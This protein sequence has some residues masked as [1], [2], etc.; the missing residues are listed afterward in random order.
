MKIAFV[1]PWYGRDIGGGAEAECRGLVHSL[2]Q[3]R[4]DIHIE[5][6]TTCMKEFSADWNDNFFPSGRYSDEGVTVHRFPITPV[7]RSKFHPMNGYRLMPS[8]LHDLFLAD[9]NVRSP[10][11]QDE[12]R[13]YFDAMIQS[14]L[15]MNELSQRIHEFDIFI[16][17][18]YM[19]STAIE[20][21][22]RVGKKGVLIPCLHQE[23]YAF[24]D[25]IRNMFQR[26][27]GVLYHVP[28]E[29]KFGRRLYRTEP[30]REFLIGE[31]VDVNP[32]T[33]K[34]ERFRSARRLTRPYILYAGRKIEGKNLPLLVSFHSA[35]RE[36][37]G[38]TFPDLVIIGGGDLDYSSLTHSH[39]IHDLGFVSLEEKFDA[40]AG[41]L[42]LCQPSLNESFSIVMMEA[43]L[44]SRPILAHQH[45]DVTREHCELSGGGLIF[46]S[47][48]SYSS[49]VMKLASS[50]P[51]A[52]D[53]GRKG[54]EYVQAN[55]SPEVV[56]KRLTDALVSIHNLNG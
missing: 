2:R 48:K 34:G 52:N 13:M 4:P 18:P 38:E 31:K 39:G 50:A 45:C 8:V 51:S 36:R 1:L 32:P 56:V 28:S 47:E 19:F 25:C 46:H 35:A 27:G 53:M 44:Q 24:L 5:V 37:L 41:A 10:L 14:P 23:R 42:A 17:I 3:Y 15:L 29:Q 11:L 12:E 49:C 22:R 16:F 30:K 40:M 9:G 7:D 6:L 20:G 26:A 43:W 21:I 55:F 54:R 33:G